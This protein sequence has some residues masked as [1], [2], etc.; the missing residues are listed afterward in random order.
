[1]GGRYIKCDKQIFPVLKILSTGKEGNVC[2]T[3]GGDIEG[4]RTKVR[5]LK[6]SELLRLRKAKRTQHSR[7]SLGTGMVVQGNV[8]KGA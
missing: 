4:T 5:H 7:N 8:G 6:E 1:M 3:I 2:G